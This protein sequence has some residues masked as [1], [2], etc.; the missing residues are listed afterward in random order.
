MARKYRR[1]RL[2]GA[3][4]LTEVYSDNT[5]DRAVCKSLVSSVCCPGFVLQ[6]RPDITMV[7]ERSL[8]IALMGCCIWKFR[9]RGFAVAE[10]MVLWC[11]CL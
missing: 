5:G 4:F 10:S 7:F 6:E 11:E 2:R 3:D 9:E 1:G 8:Q